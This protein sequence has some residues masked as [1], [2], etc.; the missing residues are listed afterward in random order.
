[1]RIFERFT[2]APDGS[3]LDFTMTVMDP[4][5]FTEPVELKRS[6]VYRPG[7][8]VMRFDCSLDSKP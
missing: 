8:K 5:T 6:W 4:E 3:R 7:E 1:V 2:P